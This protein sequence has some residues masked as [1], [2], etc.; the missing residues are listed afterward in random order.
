[1]LSRAGKI[2]RS[3][4]DI[5]KLIEK[6]S[7]A[8]EEKELFLSNNQVKFFIDHK[9]KMM[10]FLSSIKKF[11]K[12]QTEKKENEQSKIMESSIYRTSSSDNKDIIHQINELLN[13]CTKTKSEIHSVVK[14]SQNIDKSLLMESLRIDNNSYLMTQVKPVQQQ[15][16]SLSGLVNLEFS[17]NAILFLSDLEQK[18]EELEKK[19][20]QLIKY[21]T[22]ESNLLEKKE[23]KRK[24]II[25]I[26]K[27]YSML[28][29]KYNEALKNGKIN[30]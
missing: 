11:E 25:K 9:V 14:S 5:S 20:G 30:L 24:N 8:K 19:I 18:F 3:T 12:E 26:K 23:E 21:S 29:S 2:Y 7:F 16:K 1:M 4:D 22:K 27:E 15:N 13:L 28:K 10:E 17:E 6:L